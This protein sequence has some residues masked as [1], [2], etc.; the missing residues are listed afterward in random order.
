MPSTNSY[1]DGIPWRRTTAARSAT[2][3]VP[4]ARTALQNDRNAARFAY[5][6]WATPT[7]NSTVDE[8]INGHPRLR[9]C[10]HS[11]SAFSVH[12]DPL[13]PGV[14]TVEPDEPVAP[15]EPAAVELAV[16]VRRFDRLFEDVPPPVA[17]VAVDARF[18]RRSE[19][20]DPEDEPLLDDDPLL[21]ADPL[22]DDELLVDRDSRDP[23][24]DEERPPLDA[25]ESVAPESFDVAP[26]A[27]D[28][29]VD[30]EFAPEGDG[31]VASSVRH[32]AGS[33]MPDVRFAT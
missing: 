29:P 11:N 19:R 28:D 32:F 31:E 10:H 20:D 16:V 9:F 12:V 13:V 24:V 22:V 8:S 3:S 25:V 7:R 5:T 26:A 1:S 15:P 30:L 17:S 18:D 4:A 6:Q 27:V 21:A 2:V 23:L 33:G 14:P